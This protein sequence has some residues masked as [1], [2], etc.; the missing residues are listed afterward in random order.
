MEGRYSTNQHL[1]EAELTKALAVSRTLVRQMLVRLQEE[2]LVAIAPNRGARVRAFTHE[3]TLEVLQ[4]REALE[5][6]RHLWR[7]PGRA[8]RSSR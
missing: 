7:Q 2:G 6:S 4:V 5:C 1:V 3:E 8:P